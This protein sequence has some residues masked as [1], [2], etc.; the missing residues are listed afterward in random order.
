MTTSLIRARAPA[1][2]STWPQR[3]I[4]LEWAL[5][6]AALLAIGYYA[7]VSTEAMLYQ[8]SENRA[9]STL[10]SAQGTVHRAAGSGLSAPRSTIGRLEIPRLG[11]SIIVREGVDAETLRLAVGHIPGTASPGDTG[12]VGLAGHRDTFFRRLRD[13]RAGDEVRLTTVDGRY[14]YRVR[15]TSVVAPDDTSVL[16]G[17]AR[18]SLTLVTCYPFY[19]V[20]AAPKRFIVRAEQSRDGTVVSG[21]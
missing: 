12:N 10:L 3:L 2:R 15:S 8:A 20:G 11:L 1:G 5:L 21:S 6:I 18:P 19:F 4:G 14:T 7:L 16:D 13:V 9:F 17:T